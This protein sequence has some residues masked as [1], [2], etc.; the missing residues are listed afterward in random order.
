MEEAVQT[1]TADH[2]KTLVKAGIQRYIESFMNKDGGN[3]GLYETFTKMGLQYIT[4]K[5]FDA[6]SD[7]T[8]RKLQIARLFEQLHQQLPAILIVDS[9][10]K[11]LPMN[12]TGLERVRFQNGYWYGTLQVVRQLTISVVAGTTSQTNT[13][14][15]QSLLSVMFG[16][17]KF[18]A[19]GGRMTGNRALGETWVMTLGLPVLGGIT[20]T[21][22][23]ED[24][25]DKAWATTIEI[26]D[27]LFEDSITIQQKLSTFTAGQRIMNPTGNI[28]DTPPVIYAPATIPMNQSTQVRLNYFQPSIQRVIISDPN[29]ATY[30][31]QS[32]MITPRRLGTFELQ[33]IQP[34]PPPGQGL[35][36][37]QNGSTMKVVASQ[38]IKVTPR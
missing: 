15:L 5:S 33:V 31:P 14:F 12:F 18:L 17:I 4:D 11:N 34:N 20:Q 8:L 21:P 36:N 30:E 38:T 2:I 28:G 37:Q 10:F 32:R 29:I 1:F 26:P 13:D 27:I 3:R 9:D 24:P 35:Y 6:T 23:G 25:K 16:E 19:G 7:P 22:I